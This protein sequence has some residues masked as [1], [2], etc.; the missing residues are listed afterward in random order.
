[1]VGMTIYPFL[2]RGT[3]MSAIGMQ[4]EEFS[5]ML[6]VQQQMIPEMIIGY[7]YRR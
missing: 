2:T 6:K 5:E 3:I 7:L 4:E 1:M